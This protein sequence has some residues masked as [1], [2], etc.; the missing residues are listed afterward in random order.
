MSE[1][2]NIK[3]DE[4][5]TTSLR[6]AEVFGKNQ[7]RQC[8][9]GLIE[10]RKTTLTVRLPQDFARRFKAALAL[11]GLKGQDFFEKAAREFV[12]KQKPE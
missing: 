7:D 11:A 12:E 1:L 5:V 9:E 3:N 4:A 8:K 2:I 6:I 10:E